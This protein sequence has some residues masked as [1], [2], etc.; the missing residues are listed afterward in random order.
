MRV[1]AG[2]TVKSNV[3]ISRVVMTISP[4]DPQID[5]LGMIG[6]DFI[7]NIVGTASQGVVTITNP[8]KPAL[9]AAQWNDVINFPAYRLNLNV[10]DTRCCLISFHL[11]VLFSLICVK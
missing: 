11:I 3:S 8:G 9:T 7:N 4:Y 2:L 5:H 10:S 1:F 6:N